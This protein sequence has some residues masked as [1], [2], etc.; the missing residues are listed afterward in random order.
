MSPKG[1][2]GRGVLERVITVSLGVTVLIMLVTIN[3]LFLEVSL[4]VYTYTL[5]DTIK[6]ITF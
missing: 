4:G 5:N 6:K 1:I 2:W 3:N